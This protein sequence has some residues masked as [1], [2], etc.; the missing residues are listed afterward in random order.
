MRTLADLDLSRFDFIDLGAGDG[1][2]L[3]RFQERF[4]AEGVG[5]DIDPVKVAR[6]QS[7]GR[8]VVLG[9]IGQLDEVTRVR[10]ITLDNVL[11]HLPDLAAVAHVLELTARIATDFIYIRH[12]SFEDETYLRSVGLKQFWTDWTGHTC[13]ILIQDFVE[14]FRNV[15]IG[16]VELR[17][18]GLATDSTDGTLLPL[19]APPDQ[20]RYSE[21]IHGPKPTFALAKK[22]YKEI[23]L[24]VPT[25]GA[26][27]QLFLEERDDKSVDTRPSLSNWPRICTAAAVSRAD[28]ELR[29]ARRR[30]EDLAQRRSV[31]LAGA[32][33][34]LI[35]AQNTKE[36]RTALTKMFKLLLGRL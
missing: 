28:G 4:H 29:E 16:M 32:Y 8:N 35:R 14:I 12:P 31:Q 13:H 22:I 7:L 25:S 20:G 6:A 10:F 36:A 1:E 27:N 34:G 26:G 3:V 18:N 11:E 23:D 24:L 30:V 17:F 33:G 21:E 5:I 9:D 2:S 19:D 15:G